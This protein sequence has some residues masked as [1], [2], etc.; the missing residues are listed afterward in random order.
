[1]S[2]AAAMQAVSAGAGSAV[3]TSALYPLELLK[4]MVQ[5]SRG[6]KRGARKEAG[7]SAEDEGAQDVQHSSVV[8]AARHVLRT[9]G[10]LGLY[11][12]LLPK[13]TEAVLRAVVYFYIYTLLKRAVAG[14]RPMGTLA[15]LAI[16][17][18]AGIGGTLVTSP[19]EVVTTLQQTA[20]AGRS[21]RDTVSTVLSQRGLAGFF[22]CVLSLARPPPRSARGATHAARAAGSPPPLCCAPTRPSTTPCSSS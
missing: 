15:N 20:H 5:A 17:Y 7:E 2:A 1:M 16:G 22:E 19:V 11:V 3:S 6:G 18:W 21:V 13:V 12:G 4:T 14:N 9:R 10:V 8:A